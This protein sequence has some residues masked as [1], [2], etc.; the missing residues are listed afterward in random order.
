MHISNQSWAE[1]LFLASLGTPTHCCFRI[2]STRRNVHYALRH[3]FC[4]KSGWN[5]EFKSWMISAKLR[6]GRY[7]EVPSFLIMPWWGVW[8]SM[9]HNLARGTGAP[10]HQAIQRHHPR[11]RRWPHGLEML[12]CLRLENATASPSLHATSTMVHLVLENEPKRMSCDSA[13]RQP[14]KSNSSHTKSRTL[15]WVSHLRFRGFQSHVL[16]KCGHQVHCHHLNLSENKVSP[17]LM[18]HLSMFT[19]FYHPFSHFNGHIG[20]EESKLQSLGVEPEEIGFE[21]RLKSLRRDALTCW[22]NFHYLLCRSIHKS[23]Y[24]CM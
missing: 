1:H 3:V 24:V 6:Y 22:A 11:L 14:I 23:M 21:A 7:V 18:I 9:A 10:S 19:Y 17:N 15:I 2:C 12:K 8:H 20:A 13:W 16:L 4:Q 5:V